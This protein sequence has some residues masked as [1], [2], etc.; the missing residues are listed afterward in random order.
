[1]SSEGGFK[2]IPN[3]RAEGKAVGAPHYFTGIPCKHGHVDKR[4]VSTG[5]CAECLRVRQ[6]F[7]RLHDQQYREK[8]KN[9]S[10][11]RMRRLHAD[12]EIRA[13]IL[14]AE[15]R[16][17]HASED[18]RRKKAE[19]DK[20][21]QST[22]EFAEAR[23]SRERVRYHTAWKFDPDY[24]SATAR[25]GKTYA[26]RNSAKLN[27]K[28]G[29]RR[30][31]RIQATPRWL[32]EDDKKNIELIYHWAKVLARVTGVKYEVDHV[33]PLNNECV[34]GL[35]VP[36]NLQVLTESANRAKSN[37]FSPDNYDR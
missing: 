11:E 23:R 37:R 19:R 27:A 33:V 15:S 22:A 2:S 17:Y 14:A 13:Q 31:L 20:T 6:N 9:W 29:L 4:L 30:S 12:P 21:R 10:R 26:K 16:R 3:S 8:S 1:M 7:R 35:H 5:A 36:W 25:R 34:C 28:S 24:I 18:I 32:T